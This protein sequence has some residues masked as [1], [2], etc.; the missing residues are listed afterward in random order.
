MSERGLSESAA[1]PLSTSY[2]VLTLDGVPAGARDVADQIRLGLAELALTSIAGG[3][4]QVTW[5]IARDGNRDEPI[6]DEITADIVTGATAGAGGCAAS[7]NG[8]P[9]VASG[10][11]LYVAAKVD[12][13]TAVGIARLTWER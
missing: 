8:L 1:V 10:G 12:A 6:T 13:G 4:S 5:Y 3:A 7:L 11:A 2:A 9:F